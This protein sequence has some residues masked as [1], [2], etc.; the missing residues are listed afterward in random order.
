[1]KVEIT[2]IEEKLSVDEEGLYKDI[3]IHATTKLTPEVE[4]LQVNFTVIPNSDSGSLE[5]F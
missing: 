2:K 3:H 5:A 1:M 4:S